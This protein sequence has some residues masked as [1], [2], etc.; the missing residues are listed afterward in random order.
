MAKIELADREVKLDEAAAMADLF[1]LPLDLMMGRRQATREDEIAHDVR[2]LRDIAR[3]G[4]ADVRRTTTAVSN[5]VAD[6]MFEGGMPNDI[7]EIWSALEGEAKL[8]MPATGRGPLIITDEVQQIAAQLLDVVQQ[9]RELHKSEAQPQGRVE[10]RW[11]KTVRGAQGNARR[12]PPPARQ[13]MRWLARYVDDQGREHSK[14]FGR[15]TDAQKWLDEVTAA[16][17]T[18]QYVDPKAGQVTFRD[19]AE[20]WRAMQVQRPSSRAH[21]ETMLRRHAYP[22]L[23]IAASRRSCPATYRRG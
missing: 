21:L 16:V 10:D 1:G 6:V 15:K 9:T 22:T 19:Y 8:C 13:G 11:F 17:V 4:L 18:G 23:G 2:V 20:R 14:S 3:Q 7:E 12:C 5:A